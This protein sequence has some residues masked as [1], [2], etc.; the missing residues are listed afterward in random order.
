MTAAPFDVKK[1]CCRVRDFFFSG[2]SKVCKILGVNVTGWHELKG[3]SCDGSTFWVIGEVREP[4]L[5]LPQ[6]QSAIH[7]ALEDPPAKFSDSYL[8]GRFSSLRQFE[9]TRPD[10]L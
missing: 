4:G 7:R 5:E 1:M 8:R 9:G 10:S 6:I 3:H 2:G